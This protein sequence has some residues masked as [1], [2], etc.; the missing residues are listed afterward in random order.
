[1]KTLVYFCLI[2]ILTCESK[3]FSQTFK[4]ISVELKFIDS[5]IKNEKNR[6]TGIQVRLVN[7]SNKPIYIPTILTQFIYQTSDSMVVLKSETANDYKVL[8]IITGRRQDRIVPN[9]YV[10]ITSY[11]IDEYVAKFQLKKK[12]GENLMNNMPQFHGKRSFNPLFLEKDEAFTLYHI[13]PIDQFYT[14]E[15]CY[16]LV[17]KLHERSSVDF[18]DQIDEYE[19]YQIPSMETKPIFIR[20]EERGMKYRIIVTDS[21]GK[22][23]SKFYW[24]KK[25]MIKSQTKR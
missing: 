19:K 14:E 25:E 8:T 1:M 21:I 16:K 9:I 3:V 2:F 11:K 10:G 20:V 7:R 13:L 17:L 18:P 12:F 15:G 5:L 22:R 24:P 6:E 23:V 4:G